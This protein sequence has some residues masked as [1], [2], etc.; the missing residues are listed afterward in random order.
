MW[1]PIKVSR[2]GPPIFAD[3]L[4]LFAKASRNQ[5]KTMNE[6]LKMF[7]EAS[8]EMVSREKSMI[9]VLKASRPEKHV[10][11]VAA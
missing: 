4:I 8:G 2:Y 5:M 10:C 6:Y 11:L 1:H 3:D 9:F 7:C